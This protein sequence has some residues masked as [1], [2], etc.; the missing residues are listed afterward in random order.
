MAITRET[1]IRLL[2]ASTIVILTVVLFVFF[3]II[4]SLPRG[5]GPSPGNTTQV[6]PPSRNGPPYANCDEAH[7]D[8]R[9]NILRG[10]LAYNPALDRDGDGIACDR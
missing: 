3:G 6:M 8:G 10:D 9:Y 2:V 7:A 5:P 4:P 1:K